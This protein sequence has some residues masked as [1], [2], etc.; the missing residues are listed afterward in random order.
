[1]SKEIKNGEIELYAEIKQSLEEKKAEAA[2]L[3]ATLKLSESDILAATPQLAD[4][5]RKMTFGSSDSSSSS[6]SSNEQSVEPNEAKHRPTLLA[7]QAYYNQL[8]AH[9]LH[10]KSE[11]KRRFEAL[12]SQEHELCYDILGEPI[13]HLSERKRRCV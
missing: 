2:G 6:S 4:V 3:L 11:R 8:K 10:T 1:M 7:Q 13:L 5:H 12:R 9:L